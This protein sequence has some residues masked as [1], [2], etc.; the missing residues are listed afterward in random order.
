MIDLLDHP[1]DVSRPVRQESRFFEK[2]I[3]KLSL[4]YVN[5]FITV[6]IKLYITKKK[7]NTRW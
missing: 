5:S 3:K 2:E 4:G 7:I 1:F 6:T